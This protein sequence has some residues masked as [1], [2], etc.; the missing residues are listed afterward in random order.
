LQ[1]GHVEICS[2]TRLAIVFGE[3]VKI[4]T[5][6]F[7]NNEQMLLEIEEVCFP[8]NKSKYIIP[9]LSI[10]SKFVIRSL[11]IH[12]KDMVLVLWV[13]GIDIF[14]KLHLVQTLIKVILV[15]LDD[16]E[17]HKAAGHQVHALHRFAA[18]IRD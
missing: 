13:V 10:Q 1:P 3:L 4:L 14:D 5:E 15:I 12:L 17:T 8:S 9:R 16:L 6:K 7:A 11:T 18:L 2:L